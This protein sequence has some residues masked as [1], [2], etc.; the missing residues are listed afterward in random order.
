VGGEPTSPAVRAALEVLVVRMVPS[1]A[2]RRYMS[3]EHLTPVLERTRVR[4]KEIVEDKDL[5]DTSVTV[6]AKPLTPE[7]AIGRP[8]RRDF[9]III[10]KER[11]L[12]ATFLNA[13]GHA[14]TDSAREFTGALAEVIDLPFSSNQNRAI[15]LA[16]LNAV[17]VRSSNTTATPWWG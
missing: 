3:T 12:E 9:P 2:A 1:F 6:L 8:G 11:I 5:W 14:F 15:Y 17:R 16:T 7:E 13:K 10:G 4:F